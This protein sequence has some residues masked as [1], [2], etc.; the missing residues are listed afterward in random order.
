MDL[1]MTYILTSSKALGA[2]KVVPLFYET[3]AKNLL[4]YRVSE[5]TRKMNVF[6]DYVFAL[7]KNFVFGFLQQLKPQKYI[8][9]IQQDIKIRQNRQH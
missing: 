6:F 9:F 1:R 5:N 3:R 2:S 7:H 8:P 4:L